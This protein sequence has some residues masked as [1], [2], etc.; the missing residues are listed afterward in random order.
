MNILTQIKHSD[1]FDSLKRN[2][3]EYLEVH[4]HTP[5]PLDLNWYGKSLAFFSGMNPYFNAIFYDHQNM[6]I[7]WD[8]APEW[9]SEVAKILPIINHDKGYLNDPF[10]KE[11]E[12]IARYQATTHHDKITIENIHDTI[13][14]IFQT[15]VLEGKSL[16]EML[17]IARSINIETIGVNEY[18]KKRTSNVVRLMEIRKDLIVVL[19]IQPDDYNM[20]IGLSINNDDR[21]RSNNFMAGFFEI[22]YED[23]YVM[24]Y[25]ALKKHALSFMTRL[26]E[27]KYPKIKSNPQWFN[28]LCGIYLTARSNE[29]RLKKSKRYQEYYLGRLLLWM[30][31]FCGPDTKGR[32]NYDFKSE[33]PKLQRNDSGDSIKVHELV[34]T[35][36][37]PF[38]DYRIIGES[39]SFND[40]TEIASVDCVTIPFEPNWIDNGFYN[41]HGIMEIIGK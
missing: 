9:S 12:R 18:C 38:A 25:R 1:S 32:A 11:I 16:E 20:K 31:F 28:I 21:R 22:E 13:E 2:I 5:I 15:D 24:L 36:S 19:M 17:D 40:G 26:G 3:L 4:G 34:R 41:E 39:V 10:S 33:V 7:H 30:L 14:E 27:S 29:E 8:L 37:C 23:R 35:Y 6:D